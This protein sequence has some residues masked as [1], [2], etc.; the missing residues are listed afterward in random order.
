MAG[1]SEIQQPVKQFKDLRIGSWN[2]LSL[3]RSKSLQMLFDK[4]EKYYVDITCVQKMRWIGS[5]TIEKKNW[6]IFYSYD[7]K[8]HKLGTGF[9]IHKKVKHLIMDFQPK[10][11]RMCWLRIRGNF[12]NYSIINAHAS[13]EDKSDTKKDAFYDGL[14]NL[15]DTC[16]KHDVKLIIVDLNAQIGKES[17]WYPTIGKEVY[18]Q[19][20]NENGKRLIDLAASRNM[21]IG[22]TLFPH[23][24]IHKI[25]WRSP[26]VHHFSQIDHLLI[27]S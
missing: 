9:V 10:S 7:N 22:T 3:Y 19:E 12:F 5:G 13:M 16:P 27:D 11:S 25:M 23:K 6:I 18:H 8:E 24:V 26:D 15:Y 14:R 21:V 4:L 1:L 20:S 2:V 17:I